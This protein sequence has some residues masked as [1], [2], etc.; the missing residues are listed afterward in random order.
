M[1]YKGWNENDQH[2]NFLL[3]SEFERLKSI[4]EER[5]KAPKI[6]LNDFCN[7][8]AVKGILFSIAIS[9]F[10]Q[11]TGCYTFTNYASLIFEK[12]GKTIFSSNISSIILAIAQ[13]LG[14]F[15]STQIGD[16]FG[17]RTTLGKGCGSSIYPSL[18]SIF[19]NEWW[20]D[21]DSYDVQANRWVENL[22]WRWIIWWFNMFSSAISLC[23]SI[24]GLVSFAGYL[25]LLHMDSDVTNFNWLPLL[26]LSITIFVTSAGIM[27]LSNTCAV[28]NFSTNVSGH[29]NK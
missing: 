28:E 2:Q 8:M 16:T 6:Q 14:G 21:V 27:A 9:W 20:L 24:V 11:M 26:S 3:Q 17:R 5:K 4:E 22:H 29:C 10:L 13:I 1:F 19:L 7:R 25:H 12:S 23:G 15:V 18:H